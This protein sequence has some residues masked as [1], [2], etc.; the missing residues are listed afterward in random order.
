M[1]VSAILLSI[2][3]AACVC[4]VSLA[5]TPQ[6][7]H[8]GVVRDKPVRSSRLR[9]LYDQTG[10][11]SGIGVPSQNFEDEFDIYDD[12]LA[13]DFV[14][15]EGKRWKISEIEVEGTYFDGI[16]PA[17]SL[18]IA[19]Y[20]NKQGLPGKLVAKYDEIGIAED[21]FGPLVVQLPEW[22]KLKPGRYWMSVQAN[23]DFSV[24]GEWGWETASIILDNPAVF[25]NPGD[26]FMTGCTTWAP[27]R[28]CISDFEAGDLLFALRGRETTPQGPD[29][30]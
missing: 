7:M 21:R 5:A 20:K 3:L 12:M 29:R 15:P 30:G 11:D 10:H 28:T 19:I 27:L 22:L 2:A 16:G 26:G 24:E 18:N 4:G 17:H 25:Q 14:V 13:D 23:L 1:R 9:T 6:P 8:K